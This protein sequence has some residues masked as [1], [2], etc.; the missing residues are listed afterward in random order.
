M[1]YL[2]R[3]A[4]FAKLQALVAGARLVGDEVAA[5]SA[6][7]HLTRTMS[8]VQISSWASSQTQ[9]EGT[10]TSLEACGATEAPARHSRCSPPR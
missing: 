6:R 5:G 2:P 10:W 3:D 4:A 1:K 9:E 8:I 7:S